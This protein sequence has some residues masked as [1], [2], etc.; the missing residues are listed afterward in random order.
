MSPFPSFRIRERRANT[1]KVRDKG[2]R[3]KKWP[4]RV[5]LVRSDEAAE[6]VS[7]PPQ[8][9]PLVTQQGAIFMFRVCPLIAV[10]A[11]QMRSHPPEHIFSSKALVKSRP[12]G[13]KSPRLSGCF[14]QRKDNWPC[15]S[16]RKCVRWDA[17]LSV[18]THEA[19][20]R[21]IFFLVCHSLAAPWPL[22]PHA[23]PARQGSPRR[24]SSSRQGL[25]P[26]RSHR[27]RFPIFS[28]P[29]VNLFEARS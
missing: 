11:Q 10:R 25:T 1:E 21:V 23:P 18:R 16:S 26:A 6:W 29:A 14:S 28:Q 5:A 22:R 8:K 4:R 13:E 15:T 3:R 19:T 20:V 9:I 2:A 17:H 24:A 12:R 27:A 7:G